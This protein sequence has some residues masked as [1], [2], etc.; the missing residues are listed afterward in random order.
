MKV[1][2][3]VYYMEK[4]FFLT[5][6]TRVYKIALNELIDFVSILEELKRTACIK[7]VDWLASRKLHKKFVNPI[8][9]SKFEN[10]KPI[11]ID[12]NLYEKLD[13]MVGTQINKRIA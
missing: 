3:K 5:Y 7:E 1:N 13:I 8:I 4:S 2:V 10:V 11:K 12:T 9:L 6:R